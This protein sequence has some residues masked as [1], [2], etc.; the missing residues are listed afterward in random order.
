MDANSGEPWSEA[1]I[2]DLK[3]EIAHGRTFAQTASF[4]CRDEDEVREKMKEL[5]LVERTR[6]GQ[7]QLHSDISRATT[8]TAAMNTNAMA[9]RCSTRFDTA[10]HVRFRS[11]PSDRRN[12][13]LAAPGPR[14]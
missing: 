5:G 8:T 4:L 13:P 6:V 12:T 10:A 2:R 9:P 7:S 14:R 3:N 1:D 11:F